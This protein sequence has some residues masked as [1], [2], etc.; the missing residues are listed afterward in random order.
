MNGSYYDMYAG[1]EIYDSGKEAWVLT[2]GFGFGGGVMN[3]NV[4]TGTHGDSWRGMYVN[5][6]S[7]L[8][9][10]GDYNSETQIMNS[11]LFFSTF[12]VDDGEWVSAV[13]GR[14]TRYDMKKHDTTASGFS[15][16]PF[17]YPYGS[18]NSTIL[19]YNDHSESFNEIKEVSYWN[20]TNNVPTTLFAE[21][22]ETSKLKKK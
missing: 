16:E 12:T 5:L 9:S 17:A 2:S 15:E 10:H 3:Y 11:D 19:E 1:K 22:V 6:A 21:R 20:L 13:T 7:S 14:S 4:V 18:S 8:I